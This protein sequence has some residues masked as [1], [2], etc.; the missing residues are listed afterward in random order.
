MSVSLA[1]DKASKRRKYVSALD[2]TLLVCVQ[3]GRC[4]YCKASL[5]GPW[6]EIDH[7]WRDKRDSRAS[8]LFACCGTCHNRKTYYERSGNVTEVQRMVATASAYRATL[9]QSLNVPTWLQRQLSS[10]MW[11][12]GR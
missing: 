6:F 4:A 12:P 1:T 10:L 8:N 5:G 3:H 9:E 7:I 11:Q 2:R